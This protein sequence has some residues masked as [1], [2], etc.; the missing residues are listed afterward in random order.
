MM[1]KKIIVSV[2]IFLLSVT[3][4]YAVEKTANQPS[5]V[6]QNIDSILATNKRVDMQGPFIDLAGVAGQLSPQEK[7]ALYMKYKQKF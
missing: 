4:M 6:Y 3:S 1:N 5:A 2:F 7:M